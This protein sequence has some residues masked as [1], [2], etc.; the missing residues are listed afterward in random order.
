LHFLC[1]WS[2]SACLSGVEDTV[3]NNKSSDDT[4]DDDDDSETDDETWHPNICNMEQNARSGM[5]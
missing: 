5:T 2:Q 1:D 3:D 4:D